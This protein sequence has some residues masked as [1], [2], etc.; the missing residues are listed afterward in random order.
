MWADSPATTMSIVICAGVPRAPLVDS[1]HHY[2]PV[3]EAKASPPAG[4]WPPPTT[5]TMH[6][7]RGEPPEAD[8]VARERLV[9]WPR[10]SATR[11]LCAFLSPFFCFSFFFFFL[12]L[13]KS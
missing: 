12:I 3:L 6:N 2:E 1:H 9:T 8:M 5:R 13:N 7:A 10:A 4:G 11:S